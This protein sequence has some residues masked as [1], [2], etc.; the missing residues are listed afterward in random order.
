MFCVCFSYFL[1]RLVGSVDLVVFSTWLVGLSVDSFVRLLARTDWRNNTGLY[2]LVFF[3]LSKLKTWKIPF[4]MYVWQLAWWLRTQ[5]GW[6][7]VTSSSTLTTH[8]KQT[9]KYTYSRHIIQSNQPTDRL[10]ARQADLPTKT[11]LWQ[12][13]P[14]QHIRAHFAATNQRMFKN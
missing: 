13:N 10:A 3:L 5:C 8:Y 6:L 4:I 1:G 9:I 11:Q 2:A 14:A 7:C 12:T